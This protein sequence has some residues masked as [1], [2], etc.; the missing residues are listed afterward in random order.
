MIG[1]IMTPAVSSPMTAST[2]PISP[3]ATWSKPS[4]GGPEALEVLGL[5]AG[6]YGSESPPVKG[7]FEGDEAVALRRSLLE[8]IAARDFHRAFDRLGAGIGEEH[9]VGEGLL[10]EPRREP[11]LSRDAMQIGHMPQFFRLLLERLDEMGMGVA[12]RGHRDTRG[13]VEKTFADAV[14]R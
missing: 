3:A 12:E 11:F 1:S 5:A 8:M 13:E 9:I 10:A 14:K 4:T 6:G 2:A 7:A